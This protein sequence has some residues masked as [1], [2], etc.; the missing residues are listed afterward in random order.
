MTLKYILFCYLGL[1]SLKASSQEEVEKET[2]SQ[3]L[4]VIIQQEY[5]KVA[6]EIH[7]IIPRDIRNLNVFKN[8]KNIS[9]EEVDKKISDLRDSNISLELIIPELSGRK[10]KVQK[11]KED[12]ENGHISKKFYLNN[13]RQFFN[14]DCRNFEDLIEVVKRVKKQQQGNNSDLRTLLELKEDMGPLIDFY[15]NSSKVFNYLE[16]QNSELTQPSLRVIVKEELKSIFG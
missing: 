14:K 11:L 13:V 10:R 5:K 2:I 1:L 7:I 16:Q 9:C 15:I 6:Q 8:R 4:G 3:Q 12:Y